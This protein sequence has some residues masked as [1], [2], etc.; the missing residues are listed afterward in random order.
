MYPDKSEDLFPDIDKPSVHRGNPNKDLR[1]DTAAGTCRFQ[2]SLPILLWGMRKHGG[3]SGF[4]RVKIIVKVIGFCIRFELFD[5]AVGVFGIVF[6]DPGLDTGRIENDHICFCRIDSVTDG[7]G[8]ANKLIENKGKIIEEILLEASNLRRIGD[9]VK[10]AE[11]PKVPG[12]VKENQE[13]GICW[14]RK[15]ALDN[16]CP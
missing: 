3:I 8:K 1:T 10:T 15:N 14:D 9:F 11:L 16:E 2:G 12:V 13:E 7:F 5:D 6:S 4:I